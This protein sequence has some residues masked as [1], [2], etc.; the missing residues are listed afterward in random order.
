MRKIAAVA[1]ITLSAVSTGPTTA[2]AAHCSSGW[3]VSGRAQG[4]HGGRCGSIPVVIASE[5]GSLMVTAAA[6]GGL[7]WLVRRRR[8]SS[9]RP[10]LSAETCPW[11]STDDE[12]DS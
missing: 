3:S 1:I 10:P 4:G 11:C 12:Q 6:F 7:A 5:P 2:S 9:A 8:R